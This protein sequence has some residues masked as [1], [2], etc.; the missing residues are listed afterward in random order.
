MLKYQKQITITA[1]SISKPS[2]C[3]PPFPFLDLIRPG[4]ATDKT[5]HCKDQILG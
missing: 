5:S 2:I 1:P 4:L 3:I